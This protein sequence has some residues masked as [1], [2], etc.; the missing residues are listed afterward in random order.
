MSGRRRSSLTFTMSRSNESSKDEKSNND[1]LPMAIQIFLWRQTR[2][3][4]KPRQQFCSASN[5]NGLPM[6]PTLTK[7]HPYGHINRFNPNRYYSLQRNLSSELPT[8]SMPREGK[9]FSAEKM[10]GTEQSKR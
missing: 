7:D 10:I 4:N 3:S 9:S 6:F 8:G 2:Y 5:T 1:D